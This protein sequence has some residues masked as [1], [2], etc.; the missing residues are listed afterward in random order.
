MTPSRVL[1]STR[2]VQSVSQHGFPVLRA[3]S[4]MYAC[5]CD[6]LITLSLDTGCDQRVVRLCPYK[7]D[8]FTSFKF[9]SF[10]CKKNHLPL[11]L[12][13]TPSAC[14]THLDHLHV[15]SAVTQPNLTLRKQQLLRQTKFLRCM[16]IVG[17]FLFVCFFTFVQVIS[18]ST[19]FDDCAQK[20][21]QV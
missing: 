14:V 17:F 5:Q 13:T 4:C 20:Q 19:K 7:E 9:D 10:Q 2:L 12:W 16:L 3:V 15:C 1:I 6:C 21:K 8:T 18:F 11:H